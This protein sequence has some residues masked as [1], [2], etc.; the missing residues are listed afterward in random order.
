M[1]YS[2]ATRSELVEFIYRKKW[3]NEYLINTIY[4]IGLNKN[5]I[6][7][8]EQD[9]YLLLLEEKFITMEKLVSL[10]EK[11]Q[12]KFYL[13]GLIHRQLTSSSST[14]V[15]Y[16]KYTKH[17]CASAGIASEIYSDFLF[18]FENPDAI[19]DEILISLAN[20]AYDNLDWYS[21]K[22]WDLYHQSGMTYMQLSKQTKISHNSLH[23][24]IKNAKS[25]MKKDILD[26]L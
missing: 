25:K 11:N 1:I 10:L 9:V 22:I 8:I 17:K 18:E 20:N 6:P 15:L 2:A 21:K 16:Q 4:N 19:N 3:V 7:D 23:N 5:L 26:Y 13:I 12:F 14:H 24:T